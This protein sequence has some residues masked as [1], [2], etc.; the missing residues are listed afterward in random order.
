VQ[1]KRTQGIQV[2]L[3]VRAV[4][5][6]NGSPS[7]IQDKSDGWSR[8]LLVLTVKPVPPDRVIDRCLSEKLLAEK[9]GIFLWMFEGLRRLTGNGFEFTRS[10]KSERNLAE[11]KEENCNIIGFLKDNQFVEF[12]THSGSSTAG[13]YERYNEWC[14]TNNL[15]ELKKDAFSVWLKQNHLKYGLLYSDNIIDGENKKA[16]G[17]RGIKII[18]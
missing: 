7:A 3:S 17:Y 2:T 9:E 14:V 5:F 6:S 12:E 15:R 16:R 18:N 10:E 4:C 8:R 1:A 13:L 11:M